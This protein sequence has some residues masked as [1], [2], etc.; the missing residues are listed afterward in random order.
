MSQDQYFIAVDWGSTRLR[1]FLCKHSLNANIELVARNNG[2]GVT[3]VSDSFEKTLFDCIEP[4]TTEYGRL[5]IYLAGQIGSS[6]GWRETEYL[7]CPISPEQVASKCLIFEELGHEISILPGLSCLLPNQHYDL[8]RG[9]ELQVLGWLNQRPEN[10]KGQHL[11]CLPGTHTK[12]VFVNNG[13]I[14]MFKTAMTGELY[15]I[16]VNHS[17]LIQNKTASF[18]QAAFDQGAKFTLQSEAGSFVHGL[19]SVRSK[20]LFS[21]IT[22]QQS[23]SYLSGLL[24][25]S[26]VR[27]AINANEWN[28][29]SLDKI[30]LIGAPHLS[31]S[32]A[33]VL[34]LEGYKT[35]ICKLTQTTLAGFSSV[36][37][38]T[39]SSLITTS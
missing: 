7:P 10:R 6:I 2:P 28:V 27:A 25:G 23:T 11:I 19:F 26:D 31:K 13:Q 35:E 5:P 16:L 9:E 21:Q 39:E 12:W 22:G 14:I 30:A 24:I 17:I 1:A 29:D 8:M 38:A 33:R 4:W 15:D 36:F 3:K 32:F 34:E 37:R 20:Q 18:D